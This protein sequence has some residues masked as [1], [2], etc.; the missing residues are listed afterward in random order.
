MGICVYM[1]VYLKKE[2][3]CIPKS[4]DIYFNEA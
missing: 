2:S 1:Y 3:M 4:I